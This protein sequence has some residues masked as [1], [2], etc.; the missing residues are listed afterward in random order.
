M[1]TQTRA[2]S[3]AFRAMC[4]QRGYNSKKL[5]EAIGMAEPMLSGRVR[6]RTDWRWS[7]VMAVCKVLEI[8][9]DEFARYYPGELE[10]AG[11]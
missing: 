3:L 11:E 4:C 10:A 9:L 1:S 6:Q 2:T 5:A 7:E 8:S